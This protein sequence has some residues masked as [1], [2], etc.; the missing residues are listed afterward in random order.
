M[1]IHIKDI[2]EEVIY[3]YNVLQ[4]VDEDGYIYC[5]ITGVMYWLAQAGQI[6]HLDL[7]KHL[8]SHEYFPSK[9]TP[10]LWF[11]KT[12]P[13]AFTLVV[14]NFFLIEY[15]NKKHINHLL[16]P[17]E[18]QYPVNVDWTGSKYLTMDLKWDL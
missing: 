13:I 1:R 7:V 3:E 12:K 14:D 15:I 17:V 8:K 5:E 6:S 2:P 4:F 16:K 11:H 9:Q 18:E 10:G